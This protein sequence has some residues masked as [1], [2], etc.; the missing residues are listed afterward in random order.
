MIKI[1][2]TIYSSTKNKTLQMFGGFKS[3]EQARKLLSKWNTAIG[4]KYILN[5]GDGSNGFINHQDDMID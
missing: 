5:D 4:Y 1:P 3:T 2:Y